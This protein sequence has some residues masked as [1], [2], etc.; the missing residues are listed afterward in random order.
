MAE[1]HVKVGGRSYRLVCGDGEEA[2]LRKAADYIDE[3]AQGL[4]ESL[5]AMTEGRLLLMSALMVAGEIL[6]LRQDGA[7]AD[8]KDAPD[9]AALDSLLARVEALTQRLENVG[10]RS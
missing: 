4:I 9:P 3:K 1:V 8:N 5:G 2:A 10:V 6:S 7:P